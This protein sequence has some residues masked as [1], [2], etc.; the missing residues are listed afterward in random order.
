MAASLA[1]VLCAQ[2]AAADDPDCDI[3]HRE[4][5]GAAS[6]LQVTAG[7]RFSVCL[8]ANRSTGYLWALPFDKSEGLE[9]LIYLGTR[10]QPGAAEAKGLV[11][12]P[13]SD[14]FHF[15]AAQPGKVSL[16]MTYL[17][18]WLWHEAPA[19]S[20][21]FEIVILSKTEH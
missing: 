3:R 12:V 17:R 18:P 10:Y 21:V 7:E 5:D 1:M 6:R 13:G 9:R 4:S 2:V 8:A 20:V 14:I 16:T 11:G 15:A 19:K